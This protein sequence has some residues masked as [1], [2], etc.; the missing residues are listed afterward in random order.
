MSTETPEILP[1]IESLE[2]SER[3]IVR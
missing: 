1:L 2:A 3:G